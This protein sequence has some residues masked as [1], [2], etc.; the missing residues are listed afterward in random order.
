MILTPLGGTLVLMLL[1]MAF[2]LSLQQGNP[3][4]DAPV[5]TAR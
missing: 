1:L 3:A 4:G 2:L 5:D